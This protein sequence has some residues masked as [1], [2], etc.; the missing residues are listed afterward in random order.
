MRMVWQLGQIINGSLEPVGIPGGLGRPEK[1][2]QT[3][4]ATSVLALV[5]AHFSGISSF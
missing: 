4:G 5:I 2:M 3:L 1:H